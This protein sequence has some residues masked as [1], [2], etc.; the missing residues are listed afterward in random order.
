MR[1]V[2]IQL[3][4]TVFSALRKNPEEFIQEMRI[5]AA[6][7]WYELGDIS[8]AKA[9]EIAGLTRAEFINALSRYQVDFMQ[10]TAQELAQELA[11]VD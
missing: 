6:V 8:Q 9:A 7:K 4:E 5:A 3:P 2:P 10:Y 1:T 11:N